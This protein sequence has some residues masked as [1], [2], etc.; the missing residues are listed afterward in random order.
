MTS[1]SSPPFLLHFLPTNTTTH[2]KAPNNTIHFPHCNPNFQTP[3]NK[4]S[5]FLSKVLLTGGTGKTCTHIIPH[6]LAS[7]TPF[8]LTSRA[9][10]PSSPH[11]IVKFDFTDPSTYPNAFLH[12]IAVGSPISA[13][14]REFFPLQDPKI[15]RSQGH[16]ITISPDDIYIYT[17]THTYIDHSLT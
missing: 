13:I 5:P 1:K 7:S 3:T 12:P 10:P 9:P 11:P 15:P 17:H 14:Y 2:L 4:P 16:N 8:I 6:L